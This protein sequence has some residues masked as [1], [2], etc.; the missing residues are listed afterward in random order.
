MIPSQQI[1]T[2][3]DVY[4]TQPLG[5]DGYLQ[6]FKNSK[7]LGDFSSLNAL[8][9][10]YPVRHTLSLLPT[11]LTIFEPGDA[12]T[13]NFVPL[14]ANNSTNTVIE[15]AIIN[16]IILDFTSTNLLDTEISMIAYIMQLPNTI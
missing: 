8:N 5:I 10:A 1:W 15:S 2:V 14:E 12:L 11:E 4:V 6:I 3:V 7:R 9:I 16:A 13:V